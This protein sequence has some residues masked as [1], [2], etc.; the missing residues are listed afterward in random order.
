MY[1]ILIV[2]GHDAIFQFF[3]KDGYTYSVIQEKDSLG[4]NLEALTS[5]IKLLDE[6]SYKQ[7]EEKYLEID[8]VKKVDLIYSFSEDFLLYT[9]KLVS[10]HKVKGIS[11]ELLEIIINKNLLRHNLVDTDF[12]V[13]FKELNC[14]DDLRSFY[15]NHGRIIL[16]PK[17][18]SGSEGVIKVFDQDSLKKA[19]SMIS[20]NPQDFMV[21]KYING[22]EFSIETMSKDGQH[23]VVAIT[24]K[25]LC[26]N[27]FAE[28][29][30]VLP[31]LSL[32]DSDVKKLNYFAFG[33][34]NCLN[35]KTGPNHI[36]VKLDGGKVFLIEIN[37]RVGGDYISYLINS[38][39]GRNLYQETINSYFNNNEIIM[40][41]IIKPFNFCVSRA[42]YDD[43]NRNVLSELA[44]CG[45]IIEYSYQKKEHPK[46]SDLIINS[47]KSGM[48]VFGCNN[49]EE[50]QYFINNISFVMGN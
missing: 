38:V 47:D 9:A 44:K 33:L 21:E 14:I 13:P 25:T 49:R 16:K 4:A 11:L 29:Q 19:V 46:S 43:F 27:S 32:N 37:N 5:N 1:N 40:D 24:E 31:A 2:G 36:E 7:I 26:G 30:H 23:E 10:K 15:N 17:V 3:N 41:Y 35:Y 8:K 39:T 22:Q 12:N 42:I 45:E 20:L 48:F 18:G 50:F 34:L 6:I 28:L